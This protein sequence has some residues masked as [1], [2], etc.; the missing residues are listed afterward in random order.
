M[1][2]SGM[3]HLTT[4]IIERLRATTSKRRKRNCHIAADLLE[5]ATAK[6]QRMKAT[7]DRIRKAAEA[8]QNDL[9]EMRDGTKLT[10]AGVVQCLE[11]WK[12]RAET[13]EKRLQ[14]HQSGMRAGEAKLRSAIVGASMTLDAWSREESELAE[15]EGSEL[16][17]GCC[18]AYT[19]AMHLVRSICENKLATE[20]VTEV[21]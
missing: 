21:G 11:Y 4:H 3:D 13:A 1:T 17:K 6:M 19:N 2:T 5:E 9:A 15:K 7:L 8:D 14:D 10:R 16:A 12:D 20:A 18:Y